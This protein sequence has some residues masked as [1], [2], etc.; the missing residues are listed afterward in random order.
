[1]TYAE[2]K[3]EVSYGKWKSLGM[4]FPAFQGKEEAPNTNLLPAN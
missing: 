2:A 4:K 1:M 3:W